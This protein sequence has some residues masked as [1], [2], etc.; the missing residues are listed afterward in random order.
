MKKLRVRTALSVL[1]ATAAVTALGGCVNASPVGPAPT[2]A[3]TTTVAPSPAHTTPPTATLPAAPSD[4]PVLTSR[5]AQ[6]G[7][8]SVGPFP[9]A[10]SRLNIY[11]LCT[12]EGT[13]TVSIPGAASFPYECDP[14]GEDM[15]IRNS[16]DV[17]EI[18]SVTA[19]VTAPDGVTWAM[20]LTSSND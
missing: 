9:V 17:R 10:F 16:I 11:F 12:G 6:R 13:A 20:R 19:D 4:E 2:P 8:S 15:G 18:R 1:F 7:S 3:T 5:E 14:T